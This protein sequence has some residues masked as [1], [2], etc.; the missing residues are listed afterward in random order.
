[1]EI[2]F[3]ALAEMKPRATKAPPLRDGAFDA[4]QKAE[5]DPERAVGR[6]LSFG[7]FTALDATGADANALGRSVNKGFDPLQVD[8]P[9]APR[10]VVRVRDVVSKTRAFAANVAYLCHNFAPNFGVSCRPEEATRRVR[11]QELQVPW[12][13]LATG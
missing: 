9:A 5:S 2:G 8:V 11:R 10:D 13:G 7:D 4:N 12:P 3:S 6:L 1:M